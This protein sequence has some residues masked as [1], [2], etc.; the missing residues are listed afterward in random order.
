MQPLWGKLHLPCNRTF[1]VLFEA[2]Y[3][4]I[5]QLTNQNYEVLIN[6]P[7]YIRL[8]FH[9]VMYHHNKN[10]SYLS[11]IEK[12]RLDS[13]VRINSS[14]N[15]LFIMSW[16][17]SFRPFSFLARSGRSICSTVVSSRL[18]NRIF[19]AYVRYSRKGIPPQ[20]RSLVKSVISV[21]SS[22]KAGK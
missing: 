1:F 17:K 16:P 2:E 3:T 19:M 9:F 21:C 22:A 13:R 7:K 12:Y 4:E 15:V 6:F 20:V 5:L 14:K 11:L 10:V 18:G 8:K